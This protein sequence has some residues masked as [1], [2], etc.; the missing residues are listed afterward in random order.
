MGCVTHRVVA[1]PLLSLLAQLRLLACVLH[2]TAAAPVP[3]PVL[4]AAAAATAATVAVAMVAAGATIATVVVLGAG[5][6]IVWI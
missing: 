1:H 2:C 5:G 3:V 4:C 6:R